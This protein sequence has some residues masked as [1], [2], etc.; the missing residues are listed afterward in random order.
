MSLRKP[1]G[2]LRPIAVGETF[3]RITGKVA[4]EL[5]LDRA[6]AVLEPI[7]LGVKTPNGCEAIIHATRQWFH[8]HRLIPSKTAVSVDISNAFNTVNR[9]AVLQSVRT[10][11]PSLA[12]WVDC[13]YRHDSHLFT[14]SD[15]ASDQVISSSRGVQQG[16][17]LGPVLFALAIHPVIQ[18][19]L[20][21]TERSFPA[22][23]DI[24]SFYLDDG[25]CAGDAQTVSFFLR[26]LI[27][28]LRRIGLVVNL[29]K[30][31]VIPPCATS[32]SFGPDIFPGGIWNNTACF[33]LLGAAIGTPAWCELLL[34]R[35]VRKARALIDAIGRFPDSHGAFCL[36]RSCSGWAKVSHSCRTVPPDAQP[37]GLRN[38]DTDIR[39]ALG[40][41]VGSS[42][43]DDDWRLASLG[44]ASGGVGAR[45]ASEHAPA[46]YFASFAACRDLCCIIWPSFDPLDLDEGCRLSAT[47]S[48]L[49]ASIPDGTSIYAESDAPSQRSLSA[50]LEAQSVS[51][52]LH[53][54]ALSRAR[55][56]HFAAVRAPGSGAWL[57]ATS[58]SSVTHIPSPLF[59]TALRCR[60][61][62]PIWDHDSACSLCGEVLDRWGDHAICCSGGGDRVLRHNAVR[63]VVCSAV[64]EFTSVTPELEKPGLLLPPEPPDPG[65]PGPGLSP[66]QLPHAP[67]GRRPAD[68]WVPRGISG[69]PEAWD[70]SVSSILR[71]SLLSAAHPSV[72]DVFHEVESRKNSFQNTA[73]QV[74]APLGL[75]SARS[76]WRLAAVVGPPPCAGPSRGFPLSRAPCAAWPAVNPSDISLKIAQRTSRTPQG[77]NARAV[78]RRSPGSDGGSFDSTGDMVGGSAW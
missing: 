73:A 23:L 62:M 69:L 66:D 67:S 30:T 13:C 71:P 76:S 78:L 27:R 45:S 9:S 42:L 10:H 12:P 43:S 57:T 44:I 36:L 24:C 1:N 5:I 68:V 14:G 55:R 20:V 48:A 56:C 46:A 17:P 41:L 26:A 47:E 49:G 35:R 59:R 21:D 33:K 38:A 70:F 8:A 18:E 40:R 58:A 60:L 77:E 15:A 6:R 4:V 11:F 34:G 19:A 74:A 2:T 75:P 72:A 50:K 31:E 52:L 63:N 3:R 64:A 32:Q 39:L 28:G 22:G 37:V 25:I 16:D 65:D 51:S 7:Q 61:R 54:P 53:D 29:A